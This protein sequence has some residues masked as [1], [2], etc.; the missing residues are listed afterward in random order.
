MILIKQLQN[1]TILIKYKNDVICIN[2]MEL[3]NPKTNI[4]VGTII[5]THSLKTF[6]YNIP[7]AI[8][9][10]NLGIGS[11]NKILDK[12]SY[13]T[14]LSKEQLINDSSN[15][16]FLKYR[17]IIEFGDS[18]YFEHVIQYVFDYKNGVTAFN[19]ENN[20][21]YILN[22]EYLKEKTNSM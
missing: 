15:Q 4:S 19:K 21:L 1:Q 6:N 2:R 14:G 13:K 18:K 12:T 17:D 10:Y 22:I 16:E 20:T 8:T 3:N 7:L 9:A 5:L 11:V